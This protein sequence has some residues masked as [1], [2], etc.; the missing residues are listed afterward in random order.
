MCIEIN[1]GLPGPNGD[2]IIANGWIEHGRTTLNA[3]ITFR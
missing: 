2:G 3:I 1:C